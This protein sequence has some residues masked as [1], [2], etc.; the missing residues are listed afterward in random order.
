MKRLRL[1]GLFMGKALQQRQMPGLCLAKPLYKLLIGETVGYD[2]LKDIDRQLAASVENVL[3]CCQ[4]CD[5]VRAQFL[6][7]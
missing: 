2:D 3:V 4:L 5:Y 7:M 6:R 1:V